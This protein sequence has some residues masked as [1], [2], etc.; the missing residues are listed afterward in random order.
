MA[1]TTAPASSTS[2]K[3]VRKAPPPPRSTLARKLPWNDKTGRLSPLKA[4]T[5]ALLPL[6]A[7]Y[8]LITYLA[9]GLGPRPTI[10]A[11]HFIGRWTI[12]FLLAVLAITPARRLF[13]WGKLLQIRR[14]IGLTA[15]YYILIHFS[16]YV[17]DSGFNLAFV[18]TEI[19][20]RV[21][22]TLGFTA[23]LGLITMGVTSTDGMIKRMGSLAWNRL[24]RI[25]YVIGFIGFL[26]YYMQSKADVTEA[27]LY[28]GLFL[29][30][31]G[32][33]VMAKLGWKQ[34]LVPLLLLA[35]AA[36]VTTA[37]VEAAWYELLRPGV[38]MKVIAANFDVAT[39]FKPVDMRVFT[40][41][42]QFAVLLRP[43]WW[44]LLA[45][46]AIAL[47]AEIR[48]RT[49]NLRAPRPARA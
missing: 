31:M 30:L 22:L 49:G 35:V 46:L 40:T 41:D 4:I 32:Y 7:I 27:V 19:A 16:L 15:L 28:S 14:I 43:A 13:D 24:H 1:D 42:F 48:R 9:V 23:I 45:G 38:G 29:W 8:L 34:G 11:L 6:P 18:A 39:L 21:Y 33:R 2:A 36:A 10:E 12:W 44:V 25:V 3:P 20:I 26:H 37:L 17:V 47:G 5:V